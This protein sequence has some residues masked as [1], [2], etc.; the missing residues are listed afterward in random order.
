MPNDAIVL[1]DAA[2]REHRVQRGSD[3]LITVGDVKLTIRTAPDG[4][5]HF[6]GTPSHVAWAAT[7]GGTRWVYV[8]GEVFTFE[9]DRAASTRR[10]TAGHHGSLMAPMP[11]TVRKVLVKPGDTVRRSEVLIVLEAMKMELP[12]RATADGRVDKVS[13]REGDLVQPGVPLI[14]LDEAST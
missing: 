1:R 11:A 10:R 6:P 13:C 5:L 14:E 4:S 7:V 9:A 3:G 8:D 2:G 12:I